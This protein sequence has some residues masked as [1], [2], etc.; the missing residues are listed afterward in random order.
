LVGFFNGFIDLLASCDCVC[1]LACSAGFITGFIYGWVLVKI[2]FLCSETGF[3][4]ETGF[5]QVGILAF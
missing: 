1:T 4:S 3:G 2:G 5:Y